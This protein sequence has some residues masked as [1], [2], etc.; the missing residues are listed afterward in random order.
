MQSAQAISAAYYFD[1]AAQDYSCRRCNGLVHRGSSMLGFYR[2]V[3]KL[4]LIFCGRSDLLIGRKRAADGGKFRAPIS[5]NR[6][7]AR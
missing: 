6:A 4:E 1:L 5:E 3:A 2:A 7:G